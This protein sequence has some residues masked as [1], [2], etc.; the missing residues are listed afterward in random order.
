MT[1]VRQESLRT[2]DNYVLTY[3]HSYGRV[4]GATRSLA[5]VPTKNDMMK[6]LGFATFGPNRTQPSLRIGEGAKLL[7]TFKSVNVKEVAN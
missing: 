2:N 3:G 7:K 4:V 6:M 1:D 5:M